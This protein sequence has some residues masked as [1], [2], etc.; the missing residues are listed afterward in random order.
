MDAPPSADTVLSPD[1]P[2]KRVRRTAGEIDRLYKCDTAGCGK[3]YGSEGALKMHVKLKH[4]EHP[5]NKLSNPSK[6]SPQV[7]PT[8]NDYSEYV[9][10]QLPPPC[11]P[12]NIDG[13]IVQTTGTHPV[14]PI[15][16]SH[17]ISSNTPSDSFY[18]V[19]RTPSP[20][21][22]SSPNTGVF[23]SFTLPKQSAPKPEKPVKYK[24]ESDS[25]S[26]PS[27]AAIDLLKPASNIAPLMV[28]SS[29]STSLVVAHLKIGDWERGSF[30]VN[31]IVARFAHD[32]RVI[33]WEIEEFDVRQR[34][35]FSFDA[36]VDI[37]L[38]V[39][40][41]VCDVYLHMYVIGGEENRSHC[42]SI[43]PS[44][45]IMLLAHDIYILFKYILYKYYITIFFIYL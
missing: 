9:S 31:D 2:K 33:M 12:L 26:P 39:C 6:K 24:L 44:L 36:V 21:Y 5:R 10:P 4:P 18:N 29:P 25:S 43:L 37:K 34:I 27:A 11:Q 17:V 1:Q 35:A 42:L 45:F 38:K 7:S 30:T 20:R 8:P 28:S 40:V 41:L 32:D 22:P 15:M 16:I 13:T 14:S 23:S 19:S 3:C